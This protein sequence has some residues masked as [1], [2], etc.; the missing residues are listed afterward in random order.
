M[1]RI[2]Q[3]ALLVALVTL[4]LLGPS[5]SLGGAG[6]VHALAIGAVDRSEAPLVVRLRLEAEVPARSAPMRLLVELVTDADG[7]W[8]T[9]GETLVR[10]GEDGLLLR[11]E[12]ER[13]I[14]RSGLAPGRFRVE[15]P[16]FCHCRLV[17]DSTLSSTPG[18]LFSAPTSAPFTSKGPHR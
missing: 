17:T 12:V 2:A 7:V 6:E 10:P 5:D 13:R 14:E 11:A 16:A 8:G 3:R 15:G 9:V 4:G 1:S 18:A